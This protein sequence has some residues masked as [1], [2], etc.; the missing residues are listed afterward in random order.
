M[1]KW[2]GSQD[3]GSENPSPNRDHTA[4]KESELLPPSQES[5]DQDTKKHTC[6]EDGQ[7]SL[8]KEVIINK[9]ITLIIQEGLA[10]NIADLCS[11]PLMELKELQDLASFNHHIAQEE[12]PIIKKI[13]KQVSA[14]NSH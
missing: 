6:R 8:S 7:A 5:R 12:A 10:D 13:A 4:L 11:N 3:Q 2:T 14:N 9:E 1:T